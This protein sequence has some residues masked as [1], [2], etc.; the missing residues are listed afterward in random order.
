MR[1][2]LVFIFHF[3][4]INIDIKLQNQ[5]IFN[6]NYLNNLLETNSIIPTVIE[7]LIYK[8]NRQRYFE[9]GHYCRWVIEVKYKSKYILYTYG[10]IN[11]CK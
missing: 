5:I 10:T 1:C 11:Y 9:I 4:K 8:Y 7:S 6:G 3:Y 2:L